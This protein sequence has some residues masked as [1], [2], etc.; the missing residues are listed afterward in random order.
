MNLLSV[1]TKLFVFSTLTLLNLICYGQSLS[2]Q[3]VNSSGSSFSKSTGNISSTTG[4]LIIKTFNDST[5]T[6]GGTLGSGFTS[7]AA[8]TTEVSTIVEPPKEL[9]KAKVYP[10]PTSNMLF[11]DLEKGDLVYVKIK[12]TDIQ[13]RAILNEKYLVGNNHIGIDSN[14]WIAG[15]YLLQLYSLDDQQLGV[16]QIIKK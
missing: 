3:S 1:L 9:I 10:N 15:F 13:G 12:V 5:N 11:I 6:N 14:N 8:N 16:F 4:E 7:S 2:P